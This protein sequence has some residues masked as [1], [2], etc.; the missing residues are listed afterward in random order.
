MA[1]TGSL[2]ETAP[3]H[4]AETGAEGSPGLLAAGQPIPPTLRWG[5]FLLFNSRE[6]WDFVAATKR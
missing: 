4:N 1:V 6:S 5:P 2:I 3:Y